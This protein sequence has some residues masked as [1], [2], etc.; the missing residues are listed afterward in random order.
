VAIWKGG[1]WHNM[2]LKVREGSKSSRH[3]KQTKTPRTQT[4]LGQMAKDT[5]RGEADN[6][7]QE[8]KSRTKSC[9][10][11]KERKPDRGD[12]GENVVE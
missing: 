11:S 12:K 10:E 9:I 8:G 6:R 4:K 7:P 3:T 1:E 5:V 2:G